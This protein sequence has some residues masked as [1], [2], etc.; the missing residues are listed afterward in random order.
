M[1]NII[2]TKKGKISNLKAQRGANLLFILIANRLSPYK[3]KFQ[4]L[5][6]RG[7]GLC[8]SCKILRLVGTEWLLK[9]ACQINCYRNMEINIE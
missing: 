5:N 2:V 1:I 9:R 4:S 6:C 7:F 8:G 3:G